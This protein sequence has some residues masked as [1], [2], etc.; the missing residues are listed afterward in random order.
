MKD[1]YLNAITNAG[2]RDVRIMGETH[3]PIE[4]AND[5][6]VK[7]IIEYFNIQIELI[8][9]I[10]E[11]IVSIRVHGKKSVNTASYIKG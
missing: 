6:T 7:A 10:A 2:F 11:S 1:E 8:K 5:S 3:Y 9:E 4:M